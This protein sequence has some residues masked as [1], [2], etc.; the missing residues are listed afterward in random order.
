MSRPELTLAAVRNAD[1]QPADLR[2]TK[3]DVER[4]ARAARDDGNPQLADNLLR[5]AELID[6]PEETILRVYEALRPHRST[7]AELTDVARHLEA[8][9]APANA[10]L[11]RAA[12]DAYR[13]CGTLSEV[14]GDDDQG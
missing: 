8:D 7:Y 14:S 12:R 1:L 3:Q 9:G 5:A 13:R 11:V 10:Q 6:V 2:P 4:Q